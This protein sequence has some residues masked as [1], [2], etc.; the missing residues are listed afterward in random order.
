MRSAPMLDSPAVS[1]SSSDMTKS[2]KS[3]PIVQ[4]VQNA[5]AELNDLLNAIGLRVSL[6]RHQLEES[7]NGAAEMVRGAGLV[8]KASHR[9]R[10][11]GEYVR[12]EELVA[13]MRP[14]LTRKL[15]KHYGTRS[16]FIGSEPG[17]RSALIIA[18]SSDENGA[19]KECLE[20]SGYSVVVAES[21]F[22]RVEAASVQRPF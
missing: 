1:V 8:D 3:N 11:L 21:S 2:R 19:I 20:Q 12:A 6:M 4:A 7:A 16:P 22:R 15:P 14:G 10:R 5:A 17:S 18:E 13:S 9:V